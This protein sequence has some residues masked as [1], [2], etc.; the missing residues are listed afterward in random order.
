M[1]KHFKLTNDEKEMLKENNI[2]RYRF[3]S[4]IK[5]G[6]TTDEAIML[7]S[8]FRMIDGVPTKKVY[9]ANET[10]AVTSEEYFAMRS[11]GVTLNDFCIRYRRGA[12]RHEAINTRIGESKYDKPPELIKARKKDYA[13]ILFEQS[14]KQFLEVKV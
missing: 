12:T 5:Q 6:W 9:V 11:K 4:R 13:Q 1:G 2:T 8:S 7:D 3:R 14:C 10:L